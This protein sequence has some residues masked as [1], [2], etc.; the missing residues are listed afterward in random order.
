MST[1]NDSETQIMNTKYFRKNTFLS[2][3]LLSNLFIMAP[4]LAL[5]VQPIQVKS[6]IGEPFRAQLVITDIAGVDPST[7]RASLATDN[8]FIQLGIYKRNL[9]SNLQFKTTITSPERGVIT[10]TSDRPLNDPYI[11]F[12]VHIDFGRNVRLQQVTALIDPP[13][14]RVQ[15]DSI[16]LPV[17]Q[18]QLAAASPSPPTIEQQTAS[19]ELSKATET[20]STVIPKTFQG[21]QVLETPSIFDVAQTEQSTLGTL[22]TP[23]ENPNK[24]I[25]QKP[26]A[27][28]LTTTAQSIPSTLDAAA[29]AK[30]AA[31]T[32]PASDL[33]AAEAG[34]SS[35][36]PY[37]VKRRDSLWAIARRMQKDMNVPVSVIM[38]QIQQN[39]KS[40]F[41]KGN[42]NQIRTG[43]T[44]VL[45]NQQD[46]AEPAQPSLQP[47]KVENDD[48]EN[49][50]TPA[51]RP[52][53]KQ[54]QLAKTPYTRRGRLP[55]AKMTLIAP[56]QDGSAQGAASEEQGAAKQRQLVEVN[57]KITTTRQQ[58]MS[59]SKKVSELEALIRINDQKLA[60]QNAKLA[61]LMQRL[62]NLK[63]AASQN[64]NR[65]QK[66]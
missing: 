59:L 37:M 50:K 54:N 3:L 32:K 12:V 4:A 13:M 15:T 55:D 48:I 45:P 34:Q 30:A 56:N 14:T 19:T 29:A 36:K 17:Q 60:V 5:S 20:T 44:I 58:N 57:L 8:E 7:I 43:A 51:I 1:G 6:A 40:A 65:T 27:E 10:I 64:A 47:I 21:T 18:I 53:N 46:L 62:K 61:A 66:S 2:G 35:Q 38:N 63:E 9:A 23:V 22:Q 41:I 42:P 28:E 49:N 24:P 16:N 39:N 52:K 33:A 11:E 26:T 31:D 25:E